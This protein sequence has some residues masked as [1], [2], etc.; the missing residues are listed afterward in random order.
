MPDFDTGPH[1]LVAPATPSPAAPAATV[2]QALTLAILLFAFLFSLPFLRAPLSRPA[3]P[4]APRL[5]HRRWSAAP[6]AVVL[7]AP[8]PPATATS[9]NP[10]LVAIALRLFRVFDL[11]NLIEILIRLI[12]ID[13]GRLRQRRRHR[14]SGFAGLDRAQPFE[15]EARAGSASR[16]AP[17]EHGCRSA[18]RVAPSDSRL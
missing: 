4:E 8:P 13:M 12:L 5:R 18:L 10:F 1:T 7:V 2:T 11:A 3:A 17:P 6:V 9:T 15:T 16:L 14:H